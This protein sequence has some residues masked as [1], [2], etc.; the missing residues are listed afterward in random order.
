MSCP[1]NMRNHVLDG[2]PTAFGMHSVV[3]PL[4]GGERF[5]E[6]KIPLSEQGKLLY[7]FSRIALIVRPLVTH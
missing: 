4:L 1:A 2:F 7:R 5:K 6:R 3:L